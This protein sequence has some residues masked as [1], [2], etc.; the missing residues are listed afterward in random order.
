V[1]SCRIWSSYCTQQQGVVQNSE[2]QHRGQWRR[3]KGSGAL[4]GSRLVLSSRC[5]FDTGRQKGQPTIHSTGSLTCARPKMRLLWL[6]GRVA[7]FVP[8]HTL[9]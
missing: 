9:Q 3:K 7:G 5:Q 4:K 8:C 1:N 2:G 6:G